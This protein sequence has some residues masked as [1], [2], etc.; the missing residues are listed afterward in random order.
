[1]VMQSLTPVVDL[2]VKVTI[3]T[4]LLVSFSSKQLALI[5]TFNHCLTSQPHTHLSIAAFAN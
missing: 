2:S 5:T 4:T 3:T 1:M